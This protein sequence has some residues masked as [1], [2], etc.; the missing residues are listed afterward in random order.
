MKGRVVYGFTVVD[1]HVTAAMWAQLCERSKD[2]AIMVPTS[3]QKH[4]SKICGLGTFVALTYIAVMSCK[5]RVYDRYSDT[6]NN[7]TLISGEISHADNQLY[8]GK[9]EPIQWIWQ[10][11]NGVRASIPASAKA[12]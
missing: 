6:T 5:G 9:A 10:L 1:S 2:F 3:I 4:Y 11:K 7:W 8:Y 12:I